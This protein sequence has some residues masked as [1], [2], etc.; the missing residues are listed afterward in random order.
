[1]WLRI[2]TLASPRLPFLACGRSPWREVYEAP[3]DD[4]MNRLPRL[5][6][7]TH[8]FKSNKLPYCQLGAAFP[9]PAEMIKVNSHRLSYSSMWRRLPYNVIM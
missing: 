9:G 1:M 5:A 3:N 6:V 8:Q 4:K 7:H 2:E